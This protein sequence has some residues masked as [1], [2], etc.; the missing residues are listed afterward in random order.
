MS[1]IV[2]ESIITIAIIIAASM[3]ATTMVRS[4][5]EVEVNSKVLLDTIRESISIKLK[6]IFATNASSDELKIWIKN[7]GKKEIDCKFI[8]K[9]T[10]FLG[11]RGNIKYIPL[12]GSYKPFWNYS[13]INDNI[14]NPYET[15]EI[16]VFLDTSIEPGDW[17]VRI[18][19]PLGELL[20]YEFSIG[21]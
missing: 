3:V 14:L 4:L 2:A 12:G 6:I 5:Y 8:E 7:I 10:V 1:N 13:I 9:F 19:T 15:L 11:N 21:G 17:Y 18:T 16:T 20:E